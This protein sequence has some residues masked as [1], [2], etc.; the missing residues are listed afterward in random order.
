MSCSNIPAFIPEKCDRITPNYVESITFDE[1]GISII[2]L[3]GDRFTNGLI[4]S[5]DKNK[6]RVRFGIGNFSFPIVID[7]A[8]ELTSEQ[9]AVIIKFV[10]HKN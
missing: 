1:D 8:K 3:N 10:K 4:D 2:M 6:L 7:F 5:F 9:M